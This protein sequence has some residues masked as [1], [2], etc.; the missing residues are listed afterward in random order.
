MDST[1]VNVLVAARKRADQDGG[2]IILHGVQPPQLKVFQIT[3]LTEYMN[4][5]G[6]GAVP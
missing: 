5:D 6:D 2:E 1:T 4:F 3:G